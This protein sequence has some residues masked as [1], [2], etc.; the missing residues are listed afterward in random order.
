ME[1]RGSL[2]QTSQDP[3]SL[4]NTGSTENEL[5]G[6]RRQVGTQGRDLGSQADWSWRDDS[7]VK[8]AVLTEDLGSIPSH[9]CR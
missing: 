9:S 2:A 6:Y 4:G 7:V 8:S 1:L 5:K 3:E